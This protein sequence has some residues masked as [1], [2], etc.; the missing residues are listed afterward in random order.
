M[1][2]VKLIGSIEA[3]Q[4]AKELIEDTVQLITTM[5]HIDRGVESMFDTHSL[6]YTIHYMYTYY[7]ICIVKQAEGM[8]NIA[9]C[10]CR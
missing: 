1:T 3:Q 10:L 5:D 8:S 6:Y 4:R 7:G 2:T 9:I